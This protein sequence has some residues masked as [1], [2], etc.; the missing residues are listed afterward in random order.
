MQ[1]VFHFR[2]DTIYNLTNVLA[3]DHS[4]QSRVLLRLLRIILKCRNPED[5][6]SNLSPIRD[7]PQPTTNNTPYAQTDE[8][9]SEKTIENVETDEED[10]SDPNIHTNHT[11]TVAELESAFDSQLSNTHRYEHSISSIFHHY[12]YAM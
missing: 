9:K 12:N 1:R 10:I 3:T 2:T 4:D 8:I 6:L 11:V 5:I 7:T